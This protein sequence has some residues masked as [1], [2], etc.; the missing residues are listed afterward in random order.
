MPKNSLRDAPEES[1]LT[2][3]EVLRAGAGALSL[4][5]VASISTPAVAAT[6]NALRLALLHLAPSL[7]ELDRNCDQ[8]AAATRK[9]A[10]SGAKW[11]VTSELSLTGYRFDLT[12]GTEWIKPGP[13]RWTNRLRDLAKELGVTL[14]LGH[15]EMDPL[16]GKRYNTAFVIGQTGEILGRH[17]KINT[18]PVAEEW[19]TKGPEPAPIKVGGLSVGVLICADAWPPMHASVLAGKGA[20]LLVSPATWPPE[21]HGPEQCWEQRTRDTGLPLFVCNRTGIERNFDTRAS[22][23]V[24]VSAGKRLVRHTSDHST[25]VCVDWDLQ[26]QKLL[27]QSVLSL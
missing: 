3:R 9:A 14:V 22:E 13:D 2:R 21:P 8:V 4:S 27:R 26:N 6:K 1:K 5:A 11:I 24:A 20:Q 17:R 23:T 10:A 16:D 19:S 25:V 15:L 12:I 7:G 18:I